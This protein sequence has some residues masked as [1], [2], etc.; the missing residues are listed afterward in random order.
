VLAALRE[1]LAQYG[2][3]L[4]PDKTRLIEF[5]VRAATDRDRQGRGKPETFD[6]LG[7]THVCGKTR[8]GRFTVLRRTARK[9]VRAKLHE[10]NVEL[11]RRWHDP[12]PELGRWLGS[13]VRG[14]NNSAFR[15]DPGAKEDALAE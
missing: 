13:L 2:L 5:G 4:H 12:V 1:R 10:L 8:E 14:H 9:R 7:F 15:P 6:F 11:R 3:E